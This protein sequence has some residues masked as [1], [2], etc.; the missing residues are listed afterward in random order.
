MPK[1][2][3]WDNVYV[4]AIAAIA[5]VATILSFMLQLLGA[6]DFWNNLLVPIGSFFSISVP[7]FWIPIAF[8]I[9]F[10]VFFASPLYMISYIPLLNLRKLI[11]LL[12]PV[13]WTKLMQ[14]L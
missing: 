14:D 12:M 6:F 13:Y 5:S 3:I 10:F 11:A 1:K 2:S 9:G 4:K 7:L 8:V